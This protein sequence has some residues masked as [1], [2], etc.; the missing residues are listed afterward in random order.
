ML[1]S[2]GRTSSHLRVFKP[3]SG[4]IQSCASESRCRAQLEQL[5]HLA[6][7][8]NAR[9]MDVVDAGADLVRVAIVPERVEQLHLRARGLDRD[10]VGVHRGD[11]IDDVVEL[12]VAHVGVDLRLVAHAGRTEPEGVDRPVEIVFP[13][14]LAQRQAFAQRRLVDLDDAHAGSSRDRRPRRGSRARSAG[15]RR[16]AGCRRART[17]SCR[18]V[19]GPVSMPFIGFF[20]SDCA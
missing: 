17:T 3:Q 8:G 12:G 16:C 20:V 5:G 4:L 2:A 18:M 14:R 6:D 1:T 13:L 11:R 15:R 7:L 9:R 19:T 10:D